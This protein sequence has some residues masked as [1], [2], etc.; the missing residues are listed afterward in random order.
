[1]GYIAE[2]ANKVVGGDID[3]QLVKIA[4][5]N[6]I[7]N[8]KIKVLQLDAQSLP[9]ADNNFDLILLFEAIYYIPDVL[10]FTYEAKRVLR[11]GGTIIIATANCEWHGF[12]R[13]PFSTKYYTAK[14]L[15]DLF[16]D[17][18]NSELLVG[19]HDLPKGNHYFISYVRH[20][21]VTLRLIPKTMKGKELLKRIFYGKL[22][23]IP[24]ALYDGIGELEN[25]LPYHTVKKEIQ[26]YK[27]LYLIVHFKK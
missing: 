12:N 7:D 15:L 16:T 23:P 6:S 1:L 20:V 3:E 17:E 24:N 18:S 25:L 14:E 22:K 5:T 2:V 8:P 9:F 4:A 11:P 27:Q 10:K 21:A 13:S 19:F 26:N